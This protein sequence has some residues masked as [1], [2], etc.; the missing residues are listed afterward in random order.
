[1]LGR[2]PLQPAPRLCVP[3]VICMYEP[4]VRQSEAVRDAAGSGRGRSRETQ[5]AKE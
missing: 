5:R 1:M 2:I 4:V 3:D